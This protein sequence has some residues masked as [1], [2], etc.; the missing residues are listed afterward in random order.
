MFRLA[1]GFAGLF[2]VPGHS[3]SPKI[4]YQ[5]FLATNEQTEIAGAGAGAVTCRNTR[6]CVACAVCPVLAD[7]DVGVFV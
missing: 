4:W 5:Q 2:R 3:A 6:F 1:Y 7:C